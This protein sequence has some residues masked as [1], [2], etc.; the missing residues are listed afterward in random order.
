MNFKAL[1][2]FLVTLTS[3]SIHEASLEGTFYRA[4]HN[5]H[6]QGHLTVHTGPDRHLAV[7]TRRYVYINQIGS[8][9]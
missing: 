8:N 3:D 9:A 6:P 7:F 2:N 1:I 5:G 4:K